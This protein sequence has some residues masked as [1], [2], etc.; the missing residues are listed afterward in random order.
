M[1]EA[2]NPYSYPSFT[3][4]GLG[5]IELRYT[6][7]QMIRSVLFLVF[8]FFGISMKF[9]FLLHQVQFFPSTRPDD[10]SS[11]ES[12]EIKIDM[13]AGY[14]R[15]YKLISGSRLFSSFS[16]VG[17]CILTLTLFWPESSSKLSLRVFLQY[18][19]I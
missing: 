3:N 12:R 13:F 2:H 10:E 16:R 1:A 5:V 4:E 19:L 7:F 11:E 18:I 14:V 8:L 17:L 9:G 15:A 6:S